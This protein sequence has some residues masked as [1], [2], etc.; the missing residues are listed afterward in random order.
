[1]EEGLLGGPVSPLEPTRTPQPHNLMFAEGG[2]KRLENPS[3]TDHVEVPQPQV[4]ASAN[5]EAHQPL[6]PVL[7]ESA[8][9]EDGKSTRTCLT[10]LTLSALAQSVQTTSTRQT[11]EE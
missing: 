9:V 10:G 11:E 6:G 2:A 8:I 3:T 5:G 7:V 4:A 1:V